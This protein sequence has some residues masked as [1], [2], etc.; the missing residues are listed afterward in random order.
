M[1][2]GH[3]V[4]GSANELVEAPEKPKFEL[5][6]PMFVRQ[7]PLGYRVEPSGRVVP[8]ELPPEIREKRQAEW[9]ELLDEL[10]A[11]PPDPDFMRERPMNRMVD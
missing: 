2:T 9:L 6:P 8:V 5:S 1:A 3:G 7:E 4:I 11:L 10:A